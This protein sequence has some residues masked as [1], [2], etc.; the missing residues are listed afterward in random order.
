VVDPSATGLLHFLQRVPDPRGRNGRRHPHTAMLAASVC[1]ALC[2]FPGYDG[3]AQ[4]VAAVP[5]ELWHALGGKRRPPCA[6]TFRNLLMA[7]CPARLE[8]ALREWLTEGLGL[9]LPEDEPAEIVLD[10]KAL[11]GTRAR[12]VRAAMVIAALERATGCVFSQTPVAADTNEAKAALGL[13]RELVLEGRVVVADAAYCQQDVC[14]TILREGG[15]YLVLVRDNQPR[16]H[17]EARQSCTVPPSF[18]PLR[19]ASRPAGDALG[20]HAGEE[21]RPGRTA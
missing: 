17:R 7:V 20:R 5:I 3:V 19:P 18:S 21:P 10:G 14:E 6:N 8:R 16:L 13:L 12:H 9:E 4:W 11:R 15:D 1:A 2:G